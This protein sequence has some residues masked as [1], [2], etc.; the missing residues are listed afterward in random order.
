M[1]CSIAA[2]VAAAVVVLAAC[3][4]GAATRFHS[5]LP[6]PQTGATATAPTGPVAAAPRWSVSVSLPAQVD[7]PQWVLRRAD[8]TLAVLEHERW[9]APLA[10]EL[11]AALTLHLG[12][13]IGASATGAAA[14]RLTLDVR[15]W[16]ASLGG[17]N[18]L[19][20]LWSLRR[21]S[22]S[23][24]LCQAVLEQPAGGTVDALAQSHRTLVLRLAEAM[25]ASLRG[26]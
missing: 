3:A 6:P 2:G 13:R 23:P 17:I 15:R 5:L 11:Q 20:A 25:A 12:R 16:D 4:S 22:E 9:I 18:R 14:W 19:E 26:C 10:D 7:R 24:R 8:G 1:R 21:G